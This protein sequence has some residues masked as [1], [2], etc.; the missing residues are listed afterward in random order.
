M[1][2][3]LE[4]V[5]LGAPRRQREHRIGSIQ[6]LNGGLLIH[7][8]HSCMLGRLQVEPDDVRRLRLEIRIVRDL[9]M[10]QA[11]RLDTRTR[12]HARH[13]HVVHG[14]LLRQL[15]SA[16]MRRT[17]TGLSLQRP[18]QDLRFQLRRLHAHGAAEVARVEARKPILD[19]ALLPA[20]DVVPV[21]RQRPGD[22]GVGVPSIDGQNH[23][24]A[25]R[26]LCPPAAQ[27]QSSLELF[28]LS[29]A[30]I[31]NRRGH[32]AFLAW[33]GTTVKVTVH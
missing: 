9:V 19:K 14:E 30:Q 25:S 1:P 8:E 23:P 13:Q 12:P 15:A 5:A 24:R 20:T 16:P 29:V 33:P 11:V 27:A 26:V 3:V 2:V 6:R 31:Q 32:V 21:A 7:A 10:F 17:I 28:S 18:R 4:T 22:L